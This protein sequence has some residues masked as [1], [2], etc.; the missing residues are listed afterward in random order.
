MVSL[1]QKALLITLSA[2]LPLSVSSPVLGIKTQV[3]LHV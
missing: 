1:I 3:F 2:S